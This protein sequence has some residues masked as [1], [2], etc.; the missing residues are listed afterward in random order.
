KLG[1]FDDPYVDPDEAERVVGCEEHRQLA[2]TAA[3]ETITLLK[4]ED[5][6]LPLNAGKLKTIAVIGP[7]AGRCLLGGYSSVPK[8]VV[9][10]LD[11]IRAKLGN[12]VQVVYSEGCKITQPGLWSQDEVFPSDPVEDRKLIAEAMKVAEQA[13]VIVLCVGENELTSREA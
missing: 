9:S 10:V 12:R 4:N 7:N 11:G 2:L 13:D 8:Q 6:L 3:R 5:H 1:L